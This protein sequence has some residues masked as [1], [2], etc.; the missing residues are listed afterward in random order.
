MAAQLLQKHQEQQQRLLSDRKL[1][2]PAVPN[3]HSLRKP[4]SKME[5]SMSSQQ[6]LQNMGDHMAEEFSKP[7]KPEYTVSYAA[8]YTTSAL[9]W[10]QKKNYQYEVTFSLYMLTPIEKF[11]FSM[12][13]MLCA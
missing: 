11:I 8:S 7:P 5:E 13:K 3:A 10:M 9:R 12:L 4:K 6:M 2:R 1:N